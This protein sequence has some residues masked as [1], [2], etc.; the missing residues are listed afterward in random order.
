MKPR[1]DWFQVG[2]FGAMALAWLA[3]LTVERLTDDGVVER[4]AA[5]QDLV[6]R[7]GWSLVALCRSAELQRW[8]EGAADQDE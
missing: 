4:L 7:Q 2:L 8:R 3:P 5:T 6:L 1:V